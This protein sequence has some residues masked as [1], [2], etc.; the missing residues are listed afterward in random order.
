MSEE[1]WKDIENFSNYQISSYGNIKNKTTNKLL[2]PSNKGGYLCY[3]ITNNDKKSIST[4]IHR[5]VA[6]TFIKNPENKYTVN[7]KNHNKC[8]NNINNLEW[9]TTTEQNQHKRKVP[10][11]KLR[12]ISSRKVWRIDK[13][14]NKKL[15]LYDTIRDAAKWIFDNNLTNI[16]EFNNGNNIK[17]KICAVCQERKCVS[18]GSRHNGHSKNKEYQRKTAYGY[19][20]C[21]DEETKY[22]YVDEEWKNIPSNIV[23]GTNGYKISNY[24]R[25]M[26]HKGRITEGSKVHHS[27]YIWVSVYP[28]Q[29]LLHRLIAKV[30]IP[31]PNN[32]EQVNH[33]DGNRQ[34]NNVLNLEWVTGQ[35]N[36]QH[37]CDTGL[38]PRGGKI[39]IQH[40][41]KMNKINEFKT[42]NDASKELNIS[43]CKIKNC[44]DKKEKQL[45]DFIFRYEDNTHEMSE[46]EIKNRNEKKKEKYKE[47]YE[48][49][50]NNR[51]EK[52]KCE[53]GIS[54]R[55]DCMNRH[56]KTT[57]HT[58][59]MKKIIVK[60]I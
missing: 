58:E 34:N 43:K 31:N 10:K 44:C 48:K 16:K 27:K 25:V 26:N 46:K 32:K 7:H 4:K 55:Q 14:T 39:V 53:C 21:Y 5:L 20:W 3:K 9:A 35:E 2:K 15:E 29:Y 54:I 18:G 19:K 60:V 59:L 57:R 30:F 42:L 28:K 45:G 33:I 22:K 12:L 41:L 52:I 8:D 37:A 36:V 50:K 24:A 38:I 1:I 40:D 51:K 13:D 11:E 6:T 56:K 17:T 47:N 23:N 49:I